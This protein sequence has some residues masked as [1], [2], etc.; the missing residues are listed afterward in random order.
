M[1]SSLQPHG[2]TVDSQAPLSMGFSRQESEVS[3]QTL[4]QGIF[5]TQGSNLGLPCRLQS[6][7]S[8]RVGCYWVTK[9]THTHT[10]LLSLI[11]RKLLPI[12]KDKE[13]KIQ[14]GKGYK[15]AIH[16]R[17]YVNSQWIGEKMLKFQ[18]GS[19][20]IHQTDNI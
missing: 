3:C 16:R 2:C 17:E 6:M 4:L 7:G 13:S 8:Q 11:N 12:I 5:P 15:E 9:H 20:F 19:I 18:K 10:H 14:T 1:F